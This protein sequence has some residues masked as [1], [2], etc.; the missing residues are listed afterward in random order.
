MVKIAQNKY[1]LNRHL[2]KDMKISDLSLP[3]EFLSLFDGNDY[4]LYEH[5]E[6]SME[7]IRERR[8]MILSVPTASGKTLVAYV[9]IYREYLKHGRCVYIVPLKALASEKFDELKELRRL[10][11]RV[12]IS[13]GDYEE[14]SEVLKRFDVLVCTSEKADSIFHHDPAMMFDISLIVADELHLVGDQTRGPRLEMFL[15]AARY[16]NPD[17]M[18]L[19]LSATISNSDEMARW[20]GCELVSSDF[21]PVDLKRGII[22]DAKLTFED[23]EIVSL[24]RKFELQDAISH[25]ISQGG[26]VL[27]F[28]N[29]RK[30]AEDTATKMSLSLGLGEG[31]ELE[32]DPEEK[33]D[34]YGK[35]LS[36]LIP[37][38]VAFHHAGLSTS[39][40]KIVEDSFKEGRLKVIVATPTLAAGVNLPARAVIIRDIT[41]FSDGGVGYISNTEVNQML[42]RAGR[43]KYDKVGYGIIYSANPSSLPRIREYFNG[44][45]EPVM[46]YLGSGRMIRFNSLALVSTGLGTSTDNIRS[47][48]SRALLGVQRDIGTIDNELEKSLKYLEENKLIKN[49]NGKFTVSSMGKMI[50]DLYID[51]ETAVLFRNYLSEGPFNDQCAVT[52]ISMSQDIQPVNCRGSELEMV[53]GFQMSMEIPFYDVPDYESRVK[54][55]MILLDWINEIGIDEIC[56]K[57]G[58]GPGDIQSRISTAEWMAYALG[59]MSSMIL[60]QQSE[61]FQMLSFRIREGIKSEILDLTTIPN[62][63]RVRARRLYN[64]GIR[65]VEEL[66]VST[67]DRISMIAGF[68]TRLSEETI[69]HAGNLRRRK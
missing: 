44:E 45:P 61:Y 55:A 13:V 46:S 43:P 23:S 49:L 31:E 16:M 10:G 1:I 53:E 19:G 35:I 22:S 56:E 60:P 41:R 69:S 33:Q 29:S 48:F 42:G 4:T 24:R 15:T 59:R 65:S 8:S 47:F 34:R 5:Q 32:H 12:G 38:M 18:I 66:A 62:I 28:V 54:T 36:V 30:R 58:I 2:Q 14:S 37:R 64:A 68:S 57:Y 26:Q 6:K 7:H 39:D 17:I 21:R 63:G 3:Q 52:I 9:A 25:F 50:S 20:L 40:R 51:P 67:V 11:V 27:V